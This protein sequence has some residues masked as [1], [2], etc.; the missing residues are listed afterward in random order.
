[1][2]HSV[3]CIFDQINACFSEHKRL[4]SKIFEKIF[5][6]PNL[7]MVMHVIHIKIQFLS[8]QAFSESTASTF[9]CSLKEKSL[10]TIRNALGI[11]LIIQHSANLRLTGSS[12]PGKLHELSV[13]KSVDLEHASF[14]RSSRLSAL[15]RQESC[16]FNLSIGQ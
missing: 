5:P 10:Y 11:P 14:E 4:L 16:L 9:D 13:D 3:Y 2:F 6:T 7:W 15:Q 1:M 8:C 12:S